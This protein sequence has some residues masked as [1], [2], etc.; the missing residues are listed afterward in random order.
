MSKNHTTTARR[1][2]QL[3]KKYRRKGLSDLAAAAKADA[4]LGTAV[5]RIILDSILPPKPQEGD[6]NPIEKEPEQVEES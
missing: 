5:T 3:H 6:A 1:W 4:L 2:K